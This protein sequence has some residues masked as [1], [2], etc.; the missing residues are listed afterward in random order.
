MIRRLSV[1]ALLMTALAGCDD[2][3]GA[4]AADGG[5]V[6]GWPGAELVA[7]LDLPFLVIATADGPRT[8]EAVAINP[9]NGKISEPVPALHYDAK[10]QVALSPLGDRMAY[11]DHTDGGHTWVVA[12]FGLDGDGRPVLTEERRFPVTSPGPPA[13]STTARWLDG[14]NGRYDPDTG[15][16]FACGAPLGG[17]TAWQPSDDGIHGALTCAAPGFLV[18]E[19]L[20][21]RGLERVGR[22][23]PAGP[24]TADGQ[25]SPSGLLASAAL[26]ATPMGVDGSLRAPDGRLVSGFIGQ[27]GDFITD[28]IACGIRHVE[29]HVGP[30]YSHWLHGALDPGVGLPP[31]IEHAPFDTEVLDHLNSLRVDPFSQASQGVRVA[32]GGASHDITQVTGAG[33]WILTAR[34]TDIWTSS[35]A[36]DEI[37]HTVGLV[38]YRLGAGERS[39]VYFGRGGELALP[40]Y[41]FNSW[42]APTPSG[43]ASYGFTPKGLWLPREG[44]VL[45]PDGV[46]GVGSPRG[47]GADG[48]VAH[49]PHAG[50]LLTPDGQWAYGAAG[51]P[52]NTGFL[53]ATRLLP[54]ATPRCVA[55][56]R[57]VRPFAV[58]GRA[59]LA[60]SGP[61]RLVA[62]S[63]SAAHPG[64]EVVVFGV[65]FGDAPTLTIGGA[66]VPAADV[67]EADDRHL[68]LRVSD[69]TP[70]GRIRVEGLGGFAEDARPFYL[71]R[72]PQVRHPL[73]DFPPIQPL[74][75]GFNA[76]PLSGIDPA[77]LDTVAR[78]GGGGVQPWF[79][80]GDDLV[81]LWDTP[82]PAVLWTTIGTWGRRTHI[83]PAPRP[84]AGWQFVYANG[85]DEAVQLRRL[86]DAVVDVDR[87]LALRRIEGVLSP[88]TLAAA[89]GAFDHDDRGALTVTGSPPVYVLRRVVG[90]TDIGDGW[91]TDFDDLQTPVQQGVGWPAVLGG[92]VLLT[93]NI[94][95]G[96]FGGYQA[97][98]QLSADAGAHFAE[99]VGLPDYPSLQQPVALTAGPWRGFVAHDGQPGGGGAPSTLIRI[100][101]DGAITPEAGPAPPTAA[102]PAWW[103]AGAALVAF[104]AAEQTAWALDPTRPDPRW[105]VIES[106]GQAGTV[107]GMSYDPT[108]ERFLAIGSTGGISSASADAPAAFTRLD[109]VDLPGP[110][111]DPLG[112]GALPDGTLVVPG[113]MRPTGPGTARIPGVAFRRPP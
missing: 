78:V 104:G 47:L 93:G 100:D 39:V 52:G 55:L 5:T 22:I 71:H 62:V 8:A 73:G 15:E 60:S 2:D 92:R 30:G 96:R 58:G 90:F 20:L 101:L 16:G 48:D 98:F 26:T 102:A 67:I 12:R 24:W 17:D 46:Q 111:L 14:A 84:G 63:Q 95:G 97:G 1:V 112:V 107:R 68:R 9:A 64:Q 59:A 82:E 61:A 66:P 45:L 41:Q 99:A 50:A 113:V 87:G 33:E 65:S 53:C 11:G 77:A 32:P 51:G 3:G 34:G 74:A 42:G 54:G 10:V 83:A 37:T 76:L 25:L 21:Y 88:G 56:S 29:A 4:G 36:C 86:L 40:A 19:P 80:E 13:F 7:G 89:P 72:T 94:L 38:G 49:Y 44:E 105:T 75:P 81:I 27:G 23:A 85:G 18:D 28:K 57:Y 69:A 31:Q 103:G 70:S 79:V 110:A 35:T 6:P 106:A 108:G 43:E 91:Q 109:A